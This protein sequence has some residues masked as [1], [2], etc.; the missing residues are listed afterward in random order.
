MF[1]YSF[2]SISEKF[3][4]DLFRQLFQNCFVSHFEAQ[5]MFEAEEIQC[6]ST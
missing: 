3:M 5:N 6:Y 2:E 1:K 4:T